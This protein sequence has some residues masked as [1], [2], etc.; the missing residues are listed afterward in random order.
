MRKYI[1]LAYLML[2]FVAV[3]QVPQELKNVWEN[4]AVRQK[5]DAGIK[6][7][8]MGLFTLKFPVEVENLK[9]ELVR[10]EFLFG[11]YA[12]RMM[13]EELVYQKYSKEEINR[14]EELTRRIFNYGTVATVWKKVEPE[15]CK[16]RWDYSNDKNID[17]SLDT[18]PTYTVP[19]VALN[20]CKKN[21]LVVKGHCLSWM[22]SDEHFIPNWAIEK[23]KHSIV[24]RNLN[25]HIRDVCNRY[26]NQIFIWDVVNEAADY[27]TRNS[28]RYDDYIFKAFKEAERLLPTDSVFMINE[29]LDAWM[30]YVKNEQTGRFYMLCQNLIARGAK[31]DGIGLQFHIFSINHWQKILQGERYTPYQLCKALDGY[32]RLNRPI[33]ITEITIPS[34]FEG[35]EEAQAYYAEKIY[36]LWF[37]HPAVEAITW[38]NMRDGQANAKETKFMGGLIRSDLTPKPSYKA[39]ENLIAKKWQ[40]KEEHKGKVN[41]FVFTG[42]YGKYKLTYTQNGKEFIKEIWLDK[43]SDRLKYVR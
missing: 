22:I 25:K 20:F 43:K 32:A 3:A 40:T 11:I 42:F 26:G 38:W 15:Q 34:S 23:Q 7:N 21:G 1:A 10:H 39:L 37:S 36:E 19:D 8:R 18:N 29:T 6:A 31:L 14:Y 16:M 4:P 13:S 12:S 41:E 5:I 2:G 28:I 9:V 30:Q 24:E 27:Q 35:G 33:H 17:V